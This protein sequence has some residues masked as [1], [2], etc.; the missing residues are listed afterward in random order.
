VEQALAGASTAWV[1]CRASGADPGGLLLAALEAARAEAPGTADVL[2]ERLK[3]GVPPDVLATA[4]TMLRELDVLLVEPIFFVFDDA[5][6]IGVASLPL[7]GELLDARTTRLRIV[8]CARRP[9]GLRLARLEATG[10]LTELG[11]RDLAFDAGECAELLAA[12]SG[13]EPTEGEVEAALAGHT[14]LAAR[15]RTRCVGLGGARW[16]PRA[17]PGRGGARA[18]R[19]GDPSDGAGVERRRGHHPGRRRGPC[20]TRRP[21]RPA[22]SGRAPAASCTERTDAV[23]YHPLL[24]DLLRERWLAEV[25]DAERARLLASA[26]AAL[27]ADGRLAEAIDAW[28]E[29]QQ[30]EPALAR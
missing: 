30:P 25:A 29:A 9:L 7:V 17:L 15:A 1:S 27:L 8:L 6:Q 2:L 28:L 11:E 20:A 24:R 23:A 10:R 13:R 26:A 3:G 14:R 4:R 19:P 5:E 12:R 18:A 16:R 21:R 22:R